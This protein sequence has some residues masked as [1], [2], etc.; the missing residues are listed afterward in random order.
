MTII[1]FVREDQSI[2]ALMQRFLRCFC[3]YEM[4]TVL[5]LTTSCGKEFRFGKI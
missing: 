5:F 4:M 3:R 2:R 1:V